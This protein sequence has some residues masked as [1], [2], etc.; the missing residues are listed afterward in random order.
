MINIQFIAYKG[1]L[2]II[3]VNPRSS[4]TVPYM[5]KVTGIPIIEIA[6]RVML[7]EKLV[8]MSYGVGIYPETKLVCA[9][10]PVFSTEKLPKV[11][12][13]LGLEMRSTGEVLG[14]SNSLLGALYKGLVASGMDM[15]HRN[16][17]VLVTL[18]EK[19]KRRV[20]YWLKR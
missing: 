11:E 16:K 14:V 4:R 5:S 12:A 15:S 19:D 2:Y 20:Y 10:V 17:R 18:R 1:E 6:T 3:E 13:S 9:K 8:D 7:G